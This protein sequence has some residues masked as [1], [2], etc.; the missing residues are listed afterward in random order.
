MKKVMICA[1][2]IEYEHDTEGY[3]GDLDMSEVE[4]IAAHLAIEPNFHTEECGVK[5]KEVGVSV[6]DTESP[7]D[8][9]EL[10]HNP[11]ILLTK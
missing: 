11:Q 2:R 4:D 3:W 9:R 5:L 7:V 8:W 10:K 1:I 6:V